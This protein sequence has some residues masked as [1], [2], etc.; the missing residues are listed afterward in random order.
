MTVPQAFLEKLLD[1]LA[2]AHD[3]GDLG[4]PIILSL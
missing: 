3:N 4:I 2:W 1:A